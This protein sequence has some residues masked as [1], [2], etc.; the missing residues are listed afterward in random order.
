M[1]EL[2]MTTR[3]QKPI[4]TSSTPVKYYVIYPMKKT[5]RQYFISSDTR[6]TRKSIAKNPTCL[7]VPVR[8]GSHGC[9]KQVSERHQSRLLISFVTGYHMP[10]GHWGGTGAEPVPGGVGG[11]SHGHRLVQGGIPNRPPAAT[12]RHRRHRRRAVLS[13]A[14]CS[15]AGQPLATGM[16]G[17]NFPDSCSGHTRRSRTTP[18]SRQQRRGRPVCGAADRQVHGDRGC[19]RPRA[20]EAA[21]VDR[22]A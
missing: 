6:N 18:L 10:A 3:C 16:T 15:Q 9:H 20:S 14:N 4:T 5:V 22:R 8:G 11:V 19:V 7:N 1:N 12:S 13:S 21:F 17:Q 2:H